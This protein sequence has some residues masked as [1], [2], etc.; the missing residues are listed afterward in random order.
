MHYLF[1]I[2]THKHYHTDS[3]KSDF[4][5]IDLSQEQ[6]NDDFISIKFRRYVDQTYVTGY[7]DE[8]EAI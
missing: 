2:I 7:P 4:G 6:E 3:D 5:P 1:N 8:T